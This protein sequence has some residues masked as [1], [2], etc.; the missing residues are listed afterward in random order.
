MILH[1]QLF[2]VSP[3]R[4]W[5]ESYLV[6]YLTEILSVNFFMEINIGNV[7]SLRLIVALCIV[8]KHGVFASARLLH[9]LMEQ[10]ADH[11]NGALKANALTTAYRGLTGGGVSGLQTTARAARHVVEECSTE[12]GLVPTHHLKMAERN[13]WGQPQANGKFVIHRSNA[14]F[15][16]TGMYSAG[17]STQA[18]VLT[19][20]EIPVD[21]L[22]ERKVR[23]TIMVQWPTVLDATNAPIILMSALEENAELW[24]VIMFLSLEREKIGVEFA[25]AME[26]RAYW[27]N[28]LTRNIIEDMVLQIQALLWCFLL[29]R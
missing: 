5:R 19:T 22:A 16:L 12:R 29:E 24:A 21:L 23:F 9:L 7:L 18:S 17:K 2:P 6:F 3:T 8:R 14:P 28:Q 13:V 10:A 15:P 11:V 1:M 26:I 4:V 25:A 27:K 20:F